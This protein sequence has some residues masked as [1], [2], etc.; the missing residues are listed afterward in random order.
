MGRFAG[1]RVAELAEIRSNAAGYAVGVRAASAPV[2]VLCED[3]SYPGPGWAEALIRAHED[4]V[5]AVGPVVAHAGSDGAISWADFLLGYGPWLDPTPSGDVAY[6]PG[7][8]SSYKREE[9]LAYEPE[10]ERWLEAESVLHWDLRRRGRR[11]RLEGGA[12]TNHFN[13]SRASSWLTATYLQSRTFGSR[14]TEGAGAARRLLWMLAIPLIP[15][16]RLRRSLRDLRRCP[17]APPARRVLP[18][19][20]LALLASAAGE[21]AGYALGGGSAAQAVYRYE[22]LRQRHV[23]A[24]DRAA[25]AGARFWDRAP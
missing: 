7:H 5:A 14:R 1:W 12:R 16:I 17:G 19:L 21:A 13:F 23:S 2:V 3:H 11:L 18:A 6:L 25:M 15:L 10:L 9:L 20:A 4:D 22:F 8:N 24:R